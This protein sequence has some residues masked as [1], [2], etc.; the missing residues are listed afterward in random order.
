MTKGVS[1]YW[2][3]TAA[4]I[5]RYAIMSNT[6]FN[7]TIPITQSNQKLAG[8]QIVEQLQRKIHRLETASRCGGEQVV[9]SG[10][11]DID[12]MLPERGFRRGTIIEWITPSQNSGGHGADFLS[13]MTARKACEDGG[14][15][16]VIDPDRSFYP[17]AANALGIDNSHM[18]VLRSPNHLGCSLAG[19]ESGEN[20]LY[21]AIDQTLR[22]N[23]VAAVWGALDHI[24]E[25]WFRRFQ[26]SAESSGALG[27]FIRPRHA[28]HRPS[29]AEV[30]FE[31]SAEFGIQNSEQGGRKQGGRK[32]E[33]GNTSQTVRSVGFSP[34]ATTPPEGGT[35][36]VRKIRLKL[37]RCRGALTG[38]T[39]DLNINTIT[40][41]V[42]EASRMRSDHERQLEKRYSKTGSLLVASQLANPKTRRRTKRA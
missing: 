5:T 12:R 16:V 28:L 6:R 31:I 34:P 13:L 22:C 29:W 19:K 40:G 25:R 35:D 15:L 17:P 30:Q 4:G 38:Q 42:C 21:W 41:S 10:C 39:I 27:L 1:R 3:A 24:G 33:F 14:A 7:M 37:H 23:A 8:L 11:L 20:E 9:V 18:I 32:Q 2:E 26:L 36:N